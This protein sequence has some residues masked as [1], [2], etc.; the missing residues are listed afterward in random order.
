MT[1]LRVFVSQAGAAEV[2]PAWLVKQAVVDAK[3]STRSKQWKQATVVRLPEPGAQPPL[4]GVVFKGYGDVQRLPMAQLRQRGQ[5][6]QKN[7][8]QKKSGQS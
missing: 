5:K 7:S 6:G 1:A 4:V 2:L 3:F 8:G